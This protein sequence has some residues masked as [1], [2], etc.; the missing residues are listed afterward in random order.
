MKLKN[1][2]TAPINARSKYPS[3]NFSTFFKIIKRPPNI[4]KNAIITGVI[5][6][7]T[8]GTGIKK[9]IPQSVQCAGHLIKIFSQ[10]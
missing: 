2:R 3:F 5:N 4:K 9:R 8:H 1:M 6:G 10:T 7:A